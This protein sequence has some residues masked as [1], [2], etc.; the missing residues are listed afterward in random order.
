PPKLVCTGPY[1]Y[2]RNPMLTGIF[3]LMFGIGFWIGSFSLILIFT[4]LFILANILELKKIEEP[5][6]EKRLGKEYLE[7]KQRTPMFI[8][9]LHKVLKVKR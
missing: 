9:G 4:P 3:F 7:Y 1:A 6:L 8:P 5:E 2:T